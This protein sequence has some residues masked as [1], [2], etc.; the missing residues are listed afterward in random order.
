[1]IF[2]YL[3]YTCIVSTYQFGKYTVLYVCALALNHYIDLY[4][5][6]ALLCLRIEKWSFWLTVTY[7]HSLW[8]FIKRSNGN[9]KSLL[10]VTPTSIQIRNWWVSFIYFHLIFLIMSLH[11]IKLIHMCHSK[12]SHKGSLRKLEQFTLWHTFIMSNTFVAEISLPA[13]NATI[14][15]QTIDIITSCTRVDAFLRTVL[16]KKPTKA[17]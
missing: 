17:S 1:M 2:V 4:V 12:D 13:W 3:V 8:L 14:F 11:W 15:A 5:L 16:P 7:Y 6:L 10:S 9:H